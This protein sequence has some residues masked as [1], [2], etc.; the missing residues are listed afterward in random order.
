[1]VDADIR[2]VSEI[3]NKCFD[4]PWPIEEFKSL[5]ALKPSLATVYENSDNLENSVIGYGV[6]MLFD[7]YLHIANLAVKDN[8]RRKGIG[9]AIVLY[10]LDYARIENKK[11]AILEVREQN[12]AAISLYKKFGFKE[13][14]NKKLYY[15][16]GKDA[17]VMKM[18]LKIKVVST[19]SNS[20]LISGKS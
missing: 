13:S 2:V 19:I 11:L 17:L 10:M 7:S 4:D 18:E 3:E 14:G 15:P 5:L 6:A 1:M 9:S 16:D 12:L 20:T 8:Y